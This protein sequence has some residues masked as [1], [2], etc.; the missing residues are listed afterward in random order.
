MA[1]IVEFA[2]GF[3][4]YNATIPHGERLPLRDPRAQRLRHVRGR[5]VAPHAGDRDDDGQPARPLAARPR[6]RALLR[7]HG[8]RDRPVPP[9]PRARQPPGRAAAHARGGL[10]PHRG[11][12]RQGD[13]CSSRTCGPSR[14]TSRSSSGSRPARATRRTRRRPAYIEPLPRPASTTGWD[15][16]RDE[17]FARQ[18]ASRACCPPGTRA[19]AS[20]RRGCRRGT[21]SPTTSGALY[22]RMMEVFAG[23]LT[24]T[25]A[26]VGRVLDF[27]EALGELDNTIVHRDERQ[28]RQRRGRRRRARSTSSTS[29]TSCPRAS[30]RT[31]ARIDDLGTPARQQPLPVGLGV[32]GQHAAQAVQAR[33]PRGRRHR[34]AD[35]AL[36][37]AASAR[38]GETRHQYVHAIDVHADAARADRHRA[39]GD[40][41]RR[42]ADADRGRQLRADA[43]RR[44]RAERPRHAVLRDAR[45][46]G[47]LPRRLEGGRVPPDAVHRLRRQ[48]RQPARSTTTCGSCTTS[49]R[50]SPRSHDLAAERARA[51]SRR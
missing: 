44:R 19:V 35:R 20:G 27:I 36:A 7:L 47:A 34:P 6:L 22:A 14:P 51:S 9:R 39:A 42:R 10:P 11:P 49:P 18:L 46:A 12:G 25:D 28:R 23:F 2:A 38:Q 5:Q 24:H 1:R 41:R 26:Q 30:R 17:V 29:S 4:G 33:H 3:P 45:L 48:R 8:R 32:G 31:C 37:G 40:D 16:W 50:T 43:R 21:R 15:A 13:R